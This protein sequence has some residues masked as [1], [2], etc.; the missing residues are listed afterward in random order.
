MPKNAVKNS[1][2]DSHVLNNPF[3]CCNFQILKY[4]NNRF[5]NKIIYEATIWI[6][7][8]LKIKS[9]ECSYCV[10]TLTKQTEEN[11]VDKEE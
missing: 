5:A 4:Y 11:N 6:M 10:I 8:F 7:W 9:Y 3:Q 1:V 2:S